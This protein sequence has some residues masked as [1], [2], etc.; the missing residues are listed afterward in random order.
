MTRRV[1]WVK[2]MRLTDEVFKRADDY[3]SELV[4]KA[5][6]SCS[7]GR[8]GLLPS[9]RM[10]QLSMEC[11]KQDVAVTA[12]DCLAVT[13]DGHLID[14]CFD[15]GY[16]DS[17][18]EKVSIPP[19]VTDGTLLLVATASNEWQE[20]IDGSC[21][22]KC[23]LRIIEEGANIPDNAV[24]LARLVYE[25]S[26]REDVQ[27]FVPP[28]LLVSSHY[29]YR[30]QM[31]KYNNL[32]ARLDIMVSQKL[33]T[34]GGYARMIVWPII[35]NLI[36]DLKNNGAG[37][38]P[39]DLLSSV[40]K[41]VNSFYCACTLDDGFQLADEEQFQIYASGTC[42]Y[43]K[44]YQRIQEGLDIIESICI[45]LEHLDAYVEPKRVA[46]GT[47]YIEEG[48]LRQYAVSNKVLVP[49]A[50]IAPNATVYYSTDSS[51]PHLPL[52]DGR[53]VKLDP[54]FNRSRVKES[55]RI[56][57]VRLKAE[58]N[59]AFSDMSVFEV[60]VVK[61]VSVWSGPQI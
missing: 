59:G 28:C 24:P 58:I 26:W 21:I 25:S 18:V 29:R 2:G 38:S 23:N 19:Q 35:R 48:S 12:L 7:C 56:Y 53:F 16:G 33:V 42:S 54:G 14:I 61:N 45:K 46:V 44:S 51:E 4:Q 17:G 34:S 32:M 13:K 9:S 40:Q 43:E 22:Q 5:L 1:N 37:M 41:C 10:F 60:V 11:K 36:I 50:G 3:Q 30:E 6:L 8:Y 39:S 27:S 31:E 49:V 55:E 52:E 20:T 15:G 57:S 47:P